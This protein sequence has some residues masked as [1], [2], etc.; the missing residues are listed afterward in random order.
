MTRYRPD[1]LRPASCKS[2]GAKVLWTITESGKRMP[3]D[4][5]PHPEG[6]VQ[7]TRGADEHGA[8]AWRSRYVRRGEPRPAVTRRSHFATCPHASRHRVPR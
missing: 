5:D 2:C 3:V 1:G 8:P 4:F 7:L 6:D